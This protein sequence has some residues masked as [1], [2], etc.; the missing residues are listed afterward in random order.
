MY[1]QTDTT[2]Q[3]HMKIIVLLGGLPGGAECGIALQCFGAQQQLGRKL[4]TVFQGAVPDFKG[5]FGFPS[6]PI[7][8][9][10]SPTTPGSPPR[11]PAQ[12]EVCVCCPG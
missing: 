9:T 1:S 5:R 7:N 11:P 6:F 8:G 2:K 3:S 4:S 10:T 12:A